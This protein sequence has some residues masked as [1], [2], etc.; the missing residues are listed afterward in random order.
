MLKYWYYIKNVI[1]FVTSYLPFES[2]AHTHF[3]NDNRMWVKTRPVCS[4]LRVFS[5]ISLTVSYTASKHSG[6]LGAGVS[7]YCCVKAGEM[8]PWTGHKDHHRKRK[9]N[10]MIFSLTP[11]DNLQFTNGPVLGRKPKYLKKTHA[12]G[13]DM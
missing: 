2:L 5:Y 4:L 6:S 11:R 7:K 10:L 9:K 3:L 1:L 12:G 13:K 8:H